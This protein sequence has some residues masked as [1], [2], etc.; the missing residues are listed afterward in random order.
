MEYN[1]KIKDDEGS[2]AERRIY[3]IL[4]ISLAVI[5]GFLIND[6]LKLRAFNRHEHQYNIHKGLENEQ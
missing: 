3:W 6:N 5:I 1:W 4:I 2:K